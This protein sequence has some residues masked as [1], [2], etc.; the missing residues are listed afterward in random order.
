M[1]ARRFVGVDRYKTTVWEYVV[2]VGGGACCI[3]DGG[4]AGKTGHPSW[5]QSVHIGRNG[6]SLRAIHHDHIPRQVTLRNR[7]DQACPHPDGAAVFKICAAKHQFQ[8][9]AT[10]AELSLRGERGTGSAVAATRRL[11]ECLR[12][13][14]LARSDWGQVAGLDAGIVG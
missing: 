9:G 1:A 3:P 14:W 4:P 13:D 7:Q 2:L 12:A 10:L 5:E 8:A 11:R 6:D